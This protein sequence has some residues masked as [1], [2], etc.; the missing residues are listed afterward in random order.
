MADYE[1]EFTEVNTTYLCII[2]LSNIILG[3][4]ILV[5]SAQKNSI[6]LKRILISKESLGIGQRA[7]AK[8]EEYCISVMGINRIWLDVY[9]DNYRAIH[10]Y[11]KLGY[12]VF[13]TEIENKRKILYFSKSL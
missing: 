9:D 7:L 8:L 12:Q 2:N 13:G 1:S 5:R 6:Q 3:Y 10:V 11:K 4:F